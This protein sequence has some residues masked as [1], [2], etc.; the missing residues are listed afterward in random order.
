MVD[1]DLI[2]GS[3]IA[4]EG[5]KMLAH[6]GVLRQQQSRLLERLLHGQADEDEKTLVQKVRDYRR[7]NS[8]LESLKQLGEQLVSEGEQ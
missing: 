5:L 3:P 6:S 4:K 1:E 7:D 8:F 2:R